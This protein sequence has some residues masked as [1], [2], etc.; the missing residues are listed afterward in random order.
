MRNIV[1][2]S[3]LVIM[4]FLCACSGNSDIATIAPA[5]AKTPLPIPPPPIEPTEPTEYETEEHKPSAIYIPPPPLRI[6]YP[7]TQR[8]LYNG[9]FTTLYGKNIDGV[10]YFRLSDLQNTLPIT[11]LPSGISNWTE[12]GY[13][14]VSL[15]ELLAYDFRLARIASRNTIKIEPK[16]PALVGYPVFTAQPLPQHIIDQIM[17]VSFHPRAPFDLYHLAYLTIT[18]VDFYGYRRQGNLIVA[19]AIADEV[20]DI[21]REIYEGRFPIERVR[22]I[23]YYAAD[24]YY[25]MADNN[26]V[27]FNFRYIAGTQ[28][29]S[30]HAW[31]MAIDINPVQNPFYRDGVILPASGEP[32]LNRSY[33]RP[34]MIVPGDVVYNAFTSRGWIWGGHW[35]VPLDFHHFERR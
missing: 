9:I 21:F 24:D 27:A 26:S 13:I 8:L 30:R 23:D 31:G 20:L 28:T 10:N 15:R 6:V 22:L 11:Y 33:V 16:P 7:T 14:Y 25:S 19:A 34:G 3:I 17:Y 29:L 4:L 18:H 2:I 12:G 32:Y 5:Y 35:R 1:A